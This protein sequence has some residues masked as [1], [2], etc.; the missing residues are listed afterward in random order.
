MVDYRKCKWSITVN[1]QGRLQEMYMVDYINQGH[2]WEVTN[3]RFDYCLT[4]AKIPLVRNANMTT[5]T[6]DE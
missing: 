6:N 4:K 2:Y 5:N 1:V 3:N